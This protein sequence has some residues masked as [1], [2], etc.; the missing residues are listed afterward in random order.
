MA[1][2]PRLQYA[3]GAVAI[4]DVTVGAEN[5][6]PLTAPLANV[7][8]LHFHSDLPMP[9]V[10]KVA[11]AFK[12]SGSTSI[13]AKGSN[14]TYTSETFTLFAHG[15]TG[16]PMVFGRITSLGGGAVP[17][18]GSV[19][20]AVPTG[21]G[22]R[23]HRRWCHLGADTTNV[24]LRVVT[25]TGDFAG[26]AAD[27]FP[28]MTLSWEIFV[29]NFRLDG[30]QPADSDPGKLLRMTA[31]RFTAGAGTFDSDRRYIRKGT[32]GDTPLPQGKT[33]SVTYSGNAAADAPGL[34]VRYSV[35]G[36]TDSFGVS[37]G[38]F[39]ATFDRLKLY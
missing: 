9:A 17:F 13:S 28:A 33:T 32:T 16:T 25:I 20:I 29:T 12:T 26:G 18:A 7:A 37:P 36:Y 34:Q 38:S 1:I 27:V 6:N 39:V 15:Q 23:G 8:R 24:I 30:S 3:A 2:V 11:G 31:A 10:V 4:Y 22:A 35:D 21:G 19:P 5:D 14:N